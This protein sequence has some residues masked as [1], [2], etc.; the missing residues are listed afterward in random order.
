MF[1][2]ALCVFMDTW[3]RG[4]WYAEECGGHAAPFKR[5]WALLAA[6]AQRRRFCFLTLQHAAVHNPYAVW[7]AA[8][9][10]GVP[11]FVAADA[12]RGAGCACSV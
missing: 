10:F 1:L 2:W 6:G 8:A 7:R 11:S 3:R 9:P 5:K 4:K 12:E